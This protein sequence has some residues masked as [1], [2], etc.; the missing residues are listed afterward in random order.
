MLQ[1][2]QVLKAISSVL[3][4][5]TKIDILSSG[6]VKSINIYR[7]GVQV[8]L[9]PKNPTP[10]RLQLIKSMVQAEL[11]KIPE[12]GI[13]RI[14]ITPEIPQS[15][16]EARLSKIKH[17]IA[18]ASG[19]GGVGKSTV[20]IYLALSL[21]KRGYS[22]GLLDA[23]IYGSSAHL[24]LGAKS[25]IQAKGST[26]IPADIN[27]LKMISMGYF[28]NNDSPIIWRGPLVG[29]AVRDFVELTDWGELDY[30]V[31]D[32]PPGTGDAPL[33]LAQ[34]LKIDG[35]ILV[36]TPQE[37]AASVA[38][39]SYYMFKRLGIPVLGVVENMSYYICRKCGERNQ[40][41]GSGGGEK[42]ASRTGLKLLGKLPLIPEIAES[43]D[44]AEPLD[45]SKFEVFYQEFSTITEQV[46][47]IIEDKPA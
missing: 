39:K 15:E 40:L 2:E 25:S 22:A 38:A 34:S 33:T 41:F 30:L 17:T 45:I 16:R 7:D 9:A 11:E 14:D 18:V 26:L 8:I 47:K 12:H 32:L 5:D 24:M 31:V 10:E 29:K 28:V 36:T 4:P 27:G 3:D 35:I 6:Q 43:A 20:A 19:K 37:A 1:K 44:R 21:L 23:D 42:T 46:I 13:I